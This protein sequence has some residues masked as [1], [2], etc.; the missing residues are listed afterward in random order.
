MAIDDYADIFDSAGKQ[1]GVNPQLL[2]SIAQTESSGNPDAYNSESGASGLM[3]IIPE[4]AKS[5]GINDPNDPKQAI[6]GSAKLMAE[7]LK[8]YKSIPTAVMAYHGGTDPTNWGDKTHDYAQKVMKGIDNNPTTIMGGDGNDRLSTRSLLLKSLDEPEST[9]NTPVSKVQST[10]DMLKASLEN[11]DNQGHQEKEITS[12][13][14]TL[15]PIEQSTPPPQTTGIGHT[16]GYLGRAALTGVSAIPQTILNLPTNIA[17]AAKN[18]YEELTTPQGRE[19]LGTETAP[20]KEPLSTKDFQNQLSDIGLQT[21]SNRPERLISDVV[22]GVTGG[23]TG[24]AGSVVGAIGGGLGGGG[25]GYV[26]EHGGTEGQQLAANLV[27]NLLIPGVGAAST[28]LST[29]VNPLIIE[30]AKKAEEL[31]IHIPNSQLTANTPIKWLSSVLPAI[32][33][34]GAGKEMEV[35]KAQLLRKVSNTIGEDTPHLIKEVMDSAGD[36]IGKMYDSVAEAVPN[37]HI[38]DKSLNKLANISSKV[39]A[40]LPADEASRLNGQIDDIL[41]KA[42]DN[43][44]SLPIKVWKNITDSNS[45]LTDLT[46]S[47]STLGRRSAYNI[48]GALYDALSDSAPKEAQ[49]TLKQANK[50]YKNYKTLEPLAEK[51]PI[52]GE[53]NPLLLLSKVNQ[54]GRKFKK[55][56]LEDLQNLASVGNKF[57]KQ[58]PSSGTSEKTALMG[59]L[60]AGGAGGLAT[61]LMNGDLPQAAGLLGTLAGTSIAAR[62][63]NAAIHSKAYRNMLLGNKPDYLP[64]IAGGVAASQSNNR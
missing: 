3:Q 52:T 32:P 50:F 2:R 15:P 49:T 26:R 58:M 14:P 40:T 22:T 11:D 64:G 23:A 5:L 57:F 30:A 13:S 24:G 36:R 62:S 33:F 34:S 31:G 41:N 55:G 8:R 51:D 46:K 56:G 19:V 25:S 18:A 60:G 4:T 37:V 47:L 27:G 28:A 42:A 54:T 9:N 17:S 45:N 7:N 35:A 29:K 6:T 61:N 63:A 43:G 20:F 10:R 39:K 1:Y 44:G 21:A 38:S 48:K 16:A 59:Y 12:G 53:I